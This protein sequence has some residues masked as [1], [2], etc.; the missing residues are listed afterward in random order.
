M[1]KFKSDNLRGI[2]HCFT[3]DKQQAKKIIDLNFHIGI[4]GVVTFK[5]GKI[6][7]FLNSI[8]IERIVLETDSTYLAPSPYRGKRNES[9]YLKIIAEKIADLYNLE[10]SEVSK[11]TQKNSLDIFGN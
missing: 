8:P 11:I 4:G 1:K 9:S 6:S 5:N 10:L 2:F 3:G 7:E